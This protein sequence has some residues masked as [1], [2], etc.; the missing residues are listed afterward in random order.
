MKNIITSAI[1]LLLLSPMAYAQT[2]Q[3]PLEKFDQYV[4][5]VYQ[6]EGVTYFGSE[7]R[8][9]A[10]LKKMYENRVFFA[11]YDAATI[12]VKGYPSLSSIPLF[13]VYNDNLER[14]QVF[15]FNTFNPLKYYFSHHTRATQVFVL[16]GTNKV[17]IIY[18]QTIK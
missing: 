1:L 14:D 3:P 16:D 15:D 12:A 6:G 4:A 7:T 17:L 11:T 18:P 5:E 13:S 8:N 2:Q 10:F 9:Y